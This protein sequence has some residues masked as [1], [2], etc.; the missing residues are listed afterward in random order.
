MRPPL[1]ILLQRLLNLT[2]EDFAKAL[3][4][5]FVKERHCHCH[6][7]TWKERVEGYPLRAHLND[8]YVISSRSGT[9]PC[10]RSAFD[11]GMQLGFEA[12][13]A[14][15]DHLA[16]R[17]D[18]A[19]ATALKRLSV[20]DFQADLPNL[21]RVTI[22]NLPAWRKQIPTFWW[23]AKLCFHFHGLAQTQVVA[24]LAMYDGILA[25][26]TFVVLNLLRQAK[27]AERAA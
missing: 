1:P 23:V 9:R 26:D 12:Y 7:G 19:L 2:A 4:D 17:G 20:K 5:A 11:I 21:R 24:S 22:N 13:T 18:A 16:A 27:A 14:L 3:G 15:A 6:D 8:A 10:R 25:I